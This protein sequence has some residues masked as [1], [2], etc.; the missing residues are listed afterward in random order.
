M[1]HEA[2]Y[3]LCRAGQGGIG[4]GVRIARHGGYTAVGLSRFARRG[5][6]LQGKVKRHERQ[7][8]ELSTWPRWSEKLSG[9][10]PQANPW[11][12]WDH[13]RVTVGILSALERF[14][15]ERERDRGCV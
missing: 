5:A 9:K 10:W 6:S 3:A 2:V 12:R 11:E 4:E 7:N 13:G 8:V 14:W 1:Q 15:R